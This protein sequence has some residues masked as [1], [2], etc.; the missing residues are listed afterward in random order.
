M[1][2]YEDYLAENLMQNVVSEPSSE[3]SAEAKKL[4]LTYLGFGRYSDQTG[5]VAYTVQRGR[6]VPFK[7]GEDL[8][9]M[10]TKAHEGAKDANTAKA[11]I[12][13]AQKAAKLSAQVQ[14]R[15]AKALKQ[16][17]KDAARN[18][19]MLQSVYLPQNYAPEEIQALADYTDN[20]YQP[21]NNYLY[22]GFDDMTDPQTIE[23][24]HNTMALMDGMIDKSVSPMQYTVYTG[25]SARY[26]PQDFRPGKSYVFKGYTS[27]SLDYNITLDLYGQTQQS[28]RNILQIDVQKGHKALYVDSLTGSTS[29]QEV[30]L[31]RGSKIEILS[32]PHM[33]DDQILTNYATGEPV[34]LFHCQLIQEV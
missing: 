22:K 29:D 4:G 5:Q 18:N 10:M 28:P 15:D 32:G 25:L 19:K 8:A 21:V 13:T 2:K 26:N 1:L 34:A 24:V 7:H 16:T 33:I 31:P 3:A 9:N 14:N 23:A 12:E 6:L 11:Q 27:C 20:M 30:I 17:E